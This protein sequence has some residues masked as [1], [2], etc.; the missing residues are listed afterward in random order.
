VPTRIL[1]ARRW[2]G[3]GADGTA[4]LEARLAALSG[5]QRFCSSLTVGDRPSEVASR[6]A[7]A[8]HSTAE[9]TRPPQVCVPP[10][11]TPT[12]PAPQATPATCS[13]CCRAPPRRPAPGHDP[14]V[15]P[16]AGRRRRSPGCW[17][18]IPPRCAAGST[19]TTPT[20]LTGL[21][22]PDAAG[23]RH[24][25]CGSGWLRRGTSH[26]PPPQV[27][28]RVR[29]ATAPSSK[30]VRYCRSLTM[31]RAWAPV[32]AVMQGLQG[33]SRQVFRPTDRHQQ[34]CEPRQLRQGSHFWMDRSILL[35]LRR[36]IP[37][38]ATPLGSG[39][40]SQRVQRGRPGYQRT[41]LQW[42]KPYLRPTR[43]H[44]G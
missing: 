30:A 17:A 18:A 7:E 13:P 9:P 10:A 16:G 15:P 36:N 12:P 11:W 8:F 41:S 38:R 19:A 2:A 26:M 1:S 43:H 35:W 27:Q 33:K 5:W 34:K 14:A 4:P 29:G 44:L 3:A 31:M 37:P 24:G 28:A 20:A 39:S 42:R 40:S 22:T 6:V 25:A 23:L 32:G 21:P